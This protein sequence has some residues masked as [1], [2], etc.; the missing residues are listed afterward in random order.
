ML[1][2]RLCS[3]DLSLLTVLD[4]LF[5]VKA[6]RGVLCQFGARF[7]PYNPDRIFPLS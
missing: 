2:A 3:V 1:I 5:R 7:V 6:H 4:S